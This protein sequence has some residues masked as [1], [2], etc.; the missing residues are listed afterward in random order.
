MNKKD[1]THLHTHSYYSLL[2]SIASPESLVIKARELGQSALAIMDHGN[3]FGAIDFYEAGKKHGINAIQGLEA[4]ICNDRFLKGKSKTKKVKGEEETVEENQKDNKTYHISLLVQNNVGY[5]NLNQLTTLANIEGFYSKPRI[6]KKL[7]SKYSEGLFCLSGCLGGE[8]SQLILADKFD[9][10]EKVVK[11][12]LDI[13]GETYRIELMNHFSPEDHKVM[14]ILKKFAKKYEI[15]IV[16]TNDVHYLHRSDDLTRNAIIALRDKTTLADPNLKKFDTDEFYLKS[17]DEMYDLFPENPEYLEESVKISDQC[18]VTIELGKTIFPSYEVKSGENK[19]EILTKLCR[20]G[21]KI[22]I[23]GSIPPEKEKEYSDRIK[24]EL[25]VINDNKFND[26]F[27]IVEDFCSFARRE[28]IRMSPGRGSVAGSLVSY[29]LGITH[30]DPIKYGLYFERFL[31][32]E[33]VSPPDIDMDF[34]DDRRHEVIEYAKQKYGN[35]FASTISFGTYAPRKVIRDSF[36]VFGFDLQTQDMYAKLV[37]KVIQGIP[38]PELK[39]IYK[40]SKEIADLK[41]KFPDVFALAEKLEGIPTNVSTHASAYILCDDLTDRA[42]MRYDAS[43]GTVSVGLDMYSSEKIG[44]LKMDFLGVETLAIIDNAIELIKERKGVELNTDKFLEDDEASWKLIDKG[45]TIGIFQF[46]SDGI[47]QLLK[48]AQP[49]N[50]NELADC[51]ALYRPGA[52]KFINDYCDVK[53]GRKPFEVFHP[54]MEPILRETQGQLVMQEQVMKMCVVLGKFT[55]SEADLIRRAIGK[56][57]KE[58]V[59]KGQVMFAE[60]CRANGIEEAL[61]QKIVDWMTDMSRYSFN[62]SHALAY[63]VNAFH[64]SYLKAHYPFEFQVALL[65]KKV[66]ELGDYLTRLYDGRKRGISVNGP[67]LNISNQDCSAAGEKIYF[68]LNQIKGVSSA[69]TEF[70]VKERNE[71]GEFKDYKD[72]FSRCYKFLDKGTLDGLIYSGALDNIEPVNRKWKIENLTEH[73]KYFSAIKK[74]TDESQIDMFG[75]EIQIDPKI[76]KGT[77]EKDLTMEERLEK[78]KEYIGFYVSGSPLEKYWNVI[79]GDDFSDSRQLTEDNKGEYIKIAGFIKS[80]RFFKDK[81]GNDMSSFDVEDD[82]GVFKGVV[83]SSALEK[84][85][86]LLKEKLAIIIKGRVSG[87]SI[88]VDR[89]EKLENA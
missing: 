54:L 21:W 47:R 4:Y 77:E 58:E 55:L 79:K 19:E 39:D 66:K 69:G 67:N 16:A 35:K 74:S 8:L 86:R 6:D 31:N 18:S 24:Y 38:E 46:E 83:F 12:Y 32:P 5:K 70:I 50:L 76:F 34:A 2:D 37:P 25:K 43:K 53:H 3:H 28:K 57:K 13:F 84:N 51:N 20:D 26:Y 14:A 7:L 11:E 89:L 72:L 1:F 85:K 29:L 81:N 45:D 87:N 40:A 64:A 82:Y 22:K 61:I 36:K 60:K 49:K 33:R 17:T 9:E 15:P 42:P 68:G 63:S 48:N 23:K 62:K 78:E 71:N 65:N 56:K 10:A 75:G 44:L 59:E 88:L 30:L 27:L 52:A 73:L 80:V 41:V